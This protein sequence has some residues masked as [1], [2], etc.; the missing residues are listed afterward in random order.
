[1]SKP[2]VLVADPLP[3][4]VLAVLAPDFEVRHCAGSDRE[5]LLAAVPDASAL[6]IR[7][8][9]QVDAEVLAAA[10]KLRIVSRAGVGLD[11]VDVA[12]ATR[13]GVT[14][15]NAP[16]SNVVSVAELTVGLIISMA[17]NIPAASVSVHSGE[18]RRA[19][20]QGVELAGKTVGVLGFGKVG[21]L[22]AARLLAFD[23][24]VVA[25]DPF[26]PAET[27]AR[28]GGTAVTLDELVSGSD[29]LTIHLPLTAETRGLIGEAQLNLAKPSL[30]LVN[31]ARGGIV[32]EFA[33]AQALKENRIAGAA[34]DVFEVEPPDSSPLLGIAS[35]VATPHI[36]AGTPEA[37]ERAGT[38]AVESVR[39]AL[40]GQSVPGAVN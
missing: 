2:V 7:S 14:V 16:Q 26:V 19:A 6:L 5:A 12:A 35:V 24:R 40:T 15:A 31:T 18:W 9:T 10:P 25:H 37:Q 20:F 27:V 29:F 34:L 4:H 11:N 17:R 23:M 8:A 38:E 1:V 3:A 39:L 21:R 36:G 30:R 32:D 33:L 13:A 28:A 22:V